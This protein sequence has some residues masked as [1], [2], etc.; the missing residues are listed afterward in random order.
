LNIFYPSTIS[1]LLKKNT[2]GTFDGFILD[3]KKILDKVINSTE[4]D[5]YESLVLTF[6]HILAWFTRKPEIKLLNTITEKIELLENMGIH[7][8]VIHPFDET[9]SRLTAEDF[10]Q[11]V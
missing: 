10:V 1:A 11:T 7:N 2:F 6:F 3:I 5:K 9:F 8:L 4:K